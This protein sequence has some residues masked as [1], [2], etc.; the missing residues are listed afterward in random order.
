MG[1]KNKLDKIVVVD[2]EATC[3][4]PRDSRPE[5]MR[6][7]IIEIGACFLD[8]QTGK[9]SQKTSYMVKPASSTIS[10]FC[11]EL[12]T[13]TQEQVNKG[14]PFENACNKLAKEFGSRNRVWA[15]WGDYDRKHF[16]RDCQFYN[17]GYPFGPRHVN[18]KTLF[19]MVHGL[20][21][22]LGLTRALKYSNLEFKGTQHRGDDDAFNIARVLWKT[23]RKNY[24][25]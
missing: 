3:W 25:P 13:I 19:S 24:T 10:E 15:S 21:K 1:S 8:L 5:G 23:L 9:V 2:L 22:E 7:D 17:A 4:E 12:T 14:I 16:E 18:A 6:S 11:T 20:K